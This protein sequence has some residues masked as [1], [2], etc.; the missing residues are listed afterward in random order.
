VEDNGLTAFIIFANVGDSVTVVPVE[1]NVVS[2]GT[3]E[4]ESPTFAKMMKAVSPLSSTLCLDGC[5]GRD[6]AG[7]N[8]VGAAI[9]L[10]GYLAIWLFGY[11]AIWLFGNPNDIIDQ[12]GRDAAGVN[13]VGAAVCGGAR[14]RPASDPAAA[15]RIALQ[16]VL[17]CTVLTTVLAD[18]V[19]HIAA[20][21]TTY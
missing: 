13:G 5:P 17:L 12:P 15:V 19:R 3:T 4:M 7:V 9:W 10:F 2:T 20:R 14:G 11:L 6:A 18:G 1:S 16:Y 8:G 21:R